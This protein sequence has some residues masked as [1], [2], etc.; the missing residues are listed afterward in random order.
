MAQSVYVISLGAA[1]C[2]VWGV[3]IQNGGLDTINSAVGRGEYPNGLEGAVDFTGVRSIDNSLMSLVAFNLPVL[4]V[5]FFTGRLFMAQ[6]VA[7][8]SII[9]FIFSVEGQRRKGS[10]GFG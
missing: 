2:L 4:N 3:F 5:A 8:V 1:I 10:S 9:A 7:N 6:F